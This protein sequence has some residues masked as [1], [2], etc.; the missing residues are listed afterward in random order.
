VLIGVA[1]LL[2][3]PKLVSDDPFPTLNSTGESLWFFI[4]EGLKSLGPIEG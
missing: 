1:D 4:R 3:L 2:A